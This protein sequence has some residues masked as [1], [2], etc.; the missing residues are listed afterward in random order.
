MGSSLYYKNTKEL[1]FT[2]NYRQK[3]YDTESITVLRINLME[4]PVEKSAKSMQDYDSYEWD[5]DSWL[6]D[7]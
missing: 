6:M 7:A 3:Y 1:V 4:K 2:G 5:E